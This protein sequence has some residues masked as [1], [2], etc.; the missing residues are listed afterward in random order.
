[1]KYIFMG[2]A[3]AAF[4]SSGYAAAPI[5]SG[6]I[7]NIKTADELARKTGEKITVAEFWASWCPHCRNFNASGIFERSAA[8][9]SDVNFVRISDSEAKELHMKNNIRGIPTFVFFKNGKEVMRKTGGMTES[10]I[11]VA[12]NQLQTK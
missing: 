3:L 7:T 1:M 9:H 2:I 11:S 6:T 8:K 12:I 4:I 5:G 10:E